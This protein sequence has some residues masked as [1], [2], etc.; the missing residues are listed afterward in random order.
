[1][2]LKDY[3]KQT[4]LK[5]DYLSKK[6]GVTSRTM[7]NWES[8]NK[9]DQISIKTAKKV[10]ECLNLSFTSFGNGEIKALKGRKWQL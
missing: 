6:I 5:R 8:S 10:C 4:G 1:M 9:W 3:V 7:I 2:T